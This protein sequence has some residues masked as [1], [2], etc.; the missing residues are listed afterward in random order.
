MTKYKRLSGCHFP[1]WNQRKKFYVRV[2]L[3]IIPFICALISLICFGL[4]KRIVRTGSVSI[5]YFPLR[6]ERTEEQQEER[7]N[8]EKEEM[9]E[10][11]QVKR[12]KERKNHMFSI[13][14]KYSKCNDFSFSFIW[15]LL[16]CPWLEA[17]TEALVSVE[18]FN[19]WR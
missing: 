17:D 11:E 1:T 9:N 10:I 8:K 15:L 13:F 7:K 19:H 3:K 18:N 2:Q 14:C 12:K 16:I 6:V 4:F 5:N